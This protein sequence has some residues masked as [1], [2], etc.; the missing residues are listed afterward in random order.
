MST[1]TTKNLTPEQAA[2][3]AEMVHV[4]GLDAEQISFEG[5]EL[6]PI[7]DYEAVCALS[8]KLTDIQNI[9]SE[10]SDRDLENHII[11]AKCNVILP[12][13][14]SR[15][16]EDSAQVGETFA[17]GKTILDLRMAEI[18]A[19][20]RAVRRGIRSVGVNLYKAHKTFMENGQVTAGHTAHDPRYPKYQEVKVMTAKLGWTQE[21]YEVFLAEMFEGRTS[22]KDLDD[23]ELQR[24]I[25]SLRAQVRVQSVSSKL[26]A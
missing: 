10:I 15:T 2:L 12:D 16:A 7:F 11:S 17:S 9:D 20:S 19:Q 14:R 23:L 21:E 24:L 13:G 5:I 4:H 18:V 3:V 26:A 1:T 8:L 22:Q 25:V 6:K